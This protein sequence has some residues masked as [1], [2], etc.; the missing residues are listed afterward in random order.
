MTVGQLRECSEETLLRLPNFGRTS[1]WEVREMLE[2]LGSR[3]LEQPKVSWPEQFEER[4]WDIYQRRLTGRTY[5]SIGVE[6]DLSCERVR[7]IVQKRM[8]MD[9]RTAA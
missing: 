5:R 1:L 4:N 6:Y 7:Q 3:P 8:R 2:W 9:R